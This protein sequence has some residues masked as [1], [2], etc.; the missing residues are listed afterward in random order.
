MLLA[1]LRCGIPRPVVP[2]MRASSLPTFATS[3][4]ETVITTLANGMRVASEYCPGQ[5][6]TVAVH[7]NSGSAYESKK[8]S[9]VAHFAEHLHFKGT[10]SRSRVEI[11]RSVEDMG[12]QLNAY[13]SR[14]HAVY[15]CRSFASD[16]NKSVA[17]LADLLQNSK[18]DA[19]DVERERAVILREEQEVQSQL[20]EVI[21]DHL[22]SVAFQ[23]TSY[24]QTILGPEEN[25][26][27]FKRDDLISYVQSAYA[28]NRLV[29]AASGDV[30]HEELVKLAEK[31]FAGLPKTSKIPAPQR[32]RFTSGGVIVRNDDMHEVHAAFAYEGVGW[33]DPN[34]FTFMVAQAVL[35]SWNRNSGTGS[36]LVSRL[37]ETVAADQLGQ[38]VSSFV[39]P[40]QHTG[41]FGV[42]AVSTHD[43]I[44]DMTYE[45]LSEFS[46]LTISVSDAE[47]ERAKNRV[48]AEIVAALDGTSA[49]AED[50][51]RQVLTLERRMSIAE[52]L[53]RVDAVTAA[54]FKKVM[55]D[56]LLDKEP[57]I[58]VVGPTDHLPDYNHMLAMANKYRR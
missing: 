36:H 28:G 6:A 40:Y 14:E 42:Y 22:H 41:L 50:I 43:K 13:T 53:L 27:A 12:A 39:T 1:S 11:E 23:G 35:G 48:K 10:N 52:A 55:E 26:K 54:S 4:P 21:F 56:K 33:T 9:G 18:F 47:I 5:T 15:S 57:V 29:L 19:A 58:A 25:I 44:E 30:R 8:N 45:V 38:S 51:G 17:L 2:V 46:R 37:C 34:Y 20:E 49:A 7:I 3:Q 31:E 16:V 32:P 24:G